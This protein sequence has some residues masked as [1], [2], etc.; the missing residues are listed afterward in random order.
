MISIIIIISIVSSACGA[1]R[2]PLFSSF[3]SVYLSCLLLIM[4]M[5]SLCSYRCVKVCVLIVFLAIVCFL[6]LC[7]FSFN[8]DGFLLFTY[9]FLLFYFCCSFV[10]FIFHSDFFFFLSTKINNASLFLTFNND[11]PSFFV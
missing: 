11:S 4:C 6:L 3:C 2:A 7:S 8:N 9:L 10:F 1:F 5:Y